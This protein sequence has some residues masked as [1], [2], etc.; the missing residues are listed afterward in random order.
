LAGALQAHEPP[1]AGR[2]PDFLHDA[3]GLLSF[4]GA[5]LGVYILTFTD[6]KSIAHP[7]SH[8]NQMKK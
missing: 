3:D 1:I 6:T 7:L 4:H 5:T 8:C 2:G